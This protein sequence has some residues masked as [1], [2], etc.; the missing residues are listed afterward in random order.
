MSLLKFAIGG[1]GLFLAG[2]YAWRLY[3]L[4][5]KAVV[6]ITGRVHKL[7]F[8]GLEL[9]IEYNIKNPTSTSIRMSVPLISLNYGGSVLASSSMDATRIPEESKDSKGRIII[10]PNKETG[11]IKTRVL[12][13]LLSIPPLAKD[14]IARLRDTS[15]KTTFEVDTTATV[16]TALKEI[17][18]NDK[19]TIEV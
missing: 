8:R 9:A 14:L 5:E 6:Q 12:I 13:P 15:S 16:F 19:Q 1:A 3:R 17:P 4:S 7:D 2:R 10:A 18:Y 11:F